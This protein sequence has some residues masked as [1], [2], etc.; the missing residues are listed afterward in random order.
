MAQDNASK[1]LALVVNDVD[2]VVLHGLAGVDAMRSTLPMTMIDTSTVEI[3]KLAILSWRWD[4]W[5]D[6]ELRPSRNILADVRVAKHYGI[7]YIFIDCLAIDQ[8][9]DEHQLM[10][11]VLSFSKMYQRLPVIAAYDMKGEDYVNTMRRPWIMSETRALIK[12]PYRIIYAGHET[13][14]SDHEQIN[15]MVEISWQSTF[16]ST[17]LLL[18]F[19][20]IT[21]KC[22]SDFKFIMPFY[23]RVLTKAF[24]QMSRNDYLLTIALLCA[25]DKAYERNEGGHNR[26]GEDWNISNLDFD[27]YSLRVHGKPVSWTM[28]ELY[29]MGTYVGLFIYH[30]ELHQHSVEILTDQTTARTI[31]TTLGLEG[32]E[33]EDFMANESEREQFS[34]LM[35]HTSRLPKIEFSVADV[36]PAPA[37]GVKRVNKRWYDYDS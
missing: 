16:L 15:D 28:M 36:S 22:L 24:E 2:E 9:L 26:D 25:V 33:W 3:S 10:E 19:G 7:E 13:D 32:A 21:M 4:I 37:F 27:Q 34:L 18:L 35:R 8:T 29:L 12:N 6:G 14:R 17:A 1:W 11:Q 23:A 20:E 30:R 31:F 5:H